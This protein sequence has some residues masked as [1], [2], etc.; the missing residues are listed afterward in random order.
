MR[1]SRTAVVLAHS[2]C[3]ALSRQRDNATLGKPRDCF[4]FLGHRACILARVRSTQKLLAV[5]LLVS[6]PACDGVATY[7]L[8][9][10]PSAATSKD[11]AP[12][13]PEQTAIPERPV[14]APV[15][16]LRRLSR[17]EVAASITE[18]LGVPANE[19]F[20]LLPEDD[21]EPFDNDY[22]K[23]LASLVY[24]EGADTL[25]ALVSKRAL[26]NPAIRDG[27]VQCTPSKPDDEACLRKFITDFGRKALRRPLREEEVLDL[28]DS[29]TFA[30][31][32]GKFDTAV[33]LVIRSL[34]TDAEFLFRVEL[35]TPVAGK[36][37]TFK[38]SQHE[39]AS[40]LSFALWGRTPPAWLLDLADKAELATKE[41][42]RA[43]GARLLADPRGREHVERF[44]A[45]WLGYADLPHSAELNAA[46]VA[47]TNAL[48]D[49]VV[50]TDKSDYLN[51]FRSNETYANDLL[52]SHYGLQATP[53]GSSRWISYAGTR[54]RG[55]LSHGSLLSNGAKAIDTSPTRRGKWIR[56]RLFCQVIPPPPPNVNADVPPQST[57]GS[58]CKKERYSAHAT[59]GSCASCH[60]AMDPVGF[61][62]ENYDRAGK[63]R[64]QEL[65]DASCTISGDGE[66]DG[67]GTFNGAD[68]LA[69]L[70]SDSGSL[71]PCLVK[72]VFRFTMGRWE[73]APDEGLLD[74]LR[75]RFVNNGRRFDELLLDL[76]SEPAFS[77]R[78]EGAP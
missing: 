53:N 8:E 55:V 34:L 57:T 78:V 38:L 61:G 67:I 64:T 37:G 54:R 76:V 75:T 39:L 66:L 30:A 72:Q 27:L 47:E 32:T 71:E 20:T 17:A 44:H 6:L 50:F 29:K 68:G 4:G 36:P 45:L 23:Q 46:F 3:G 5:A 48:V 18:L 49:K 69:D 24:V 70:F 40:R 26:Q 65:E 58:K 59:V 74:S 12:A 7:L 35:G 21:G 51:L 22:T 9:A 19:T 14:L 42:V 31:Q 1:A 15:T 28:L 43:A 16:E 63:W 41:Q 33:D 60:K 11:D 13:T 62:L 73:R 2:T 56:E 77:E 52:I 10:P 25:A